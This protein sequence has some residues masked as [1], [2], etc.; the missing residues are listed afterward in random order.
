[1][2]GKRREMTDSDEE[3]NGREGTCREMTGNEWDINRK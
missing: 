2:Q 1:M 3:I